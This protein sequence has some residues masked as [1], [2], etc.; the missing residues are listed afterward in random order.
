MVYY[1]VHVLADFQLWGPNN[2][3][4]DISEWKSQTNNVRFPLTCLNR[5]TVY[6]S[7]LTANVPRQI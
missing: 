4:F 6:N 3:G 7:L 2:R 1:T 5:L